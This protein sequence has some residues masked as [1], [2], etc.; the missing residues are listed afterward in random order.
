MDEIQATRSDRAKRSLVCHLLLDFVQT[1]RVP[2]SNSFEICYQALKTRTSS[3]GGQVSKG[4]GKGN[5]EGKG[6]RNLSTMTQPQ[7]NSIKS[8]ALNVSI[9]DLVTTRS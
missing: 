3:G 2:L 7:M 1:P 8:I 4:E 6:K 9:S 5:G